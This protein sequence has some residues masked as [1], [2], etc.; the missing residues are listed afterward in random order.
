MT[1]KLKQIIIDRG[2]KTGVIAA[3]VGISESAMY[4]IFRTGRAK[5]ETWQKI[6]QVLNI[7]VEYL[8]ESSPKIY[9][10]STM[11]EPPAYYGCKQCDIYSKLVTVQ[12]QCIKDL[13]K[14]IELLEEKIGKKR[15]AS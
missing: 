11:N 5:F 1:N 10:P 2:L 8:I 7:D 9:E 6:A 14:H 15:H 4:K 12:E 3:K 13:K